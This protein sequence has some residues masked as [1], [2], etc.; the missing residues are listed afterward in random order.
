MKAMT[1]HA[2]KSVQLAIV[3]MLLSLAAAATA[4]AQTTGSV[5][6]TVVD[7]TG[8][9]LPGVLVTVAGEVGSIGV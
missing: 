7:Q 8:T 2:G 5:E 9:P 6:G 1:P 3:A 4:A